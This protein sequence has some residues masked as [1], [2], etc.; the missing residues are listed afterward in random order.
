MLRTN[1]IQK[2][3]DDNSYSNYL[4]IGLGLGKN[5]NDINI[6]NKVSVDPNTE[7]GAIHQMTSDEF[8][9]SNT[10]TYDIVLVDGL[11]HAD[12]VLKDIE[13]SLKIADVVVCHDM[14]PVKKEH[15]V[16]PFSGGHWNGDCWKALVQLRQ[17][18]SDIEVVT[19]NTDEG[20]SVITKTDNG[21]TLDNELELTWENFDRN[22]EQWLNLITPEQFLQ[23]DLKSL[24]KTYLQDPDSADAN[25]KL[26]LH[27]ENIGQ[28]ASA[29]SYYVRAAERYKDK[30]YQYECMMRS[31]MCFAKQGIR[32]FSVKGMLQHAVAVLPER[33]EAYYHLTKIL[34]NEHG[35]GSWFDS[36]TYSSL[37]LKFCE[38]IEQLPPLR[39]HIDYPGLYALEFEQAH[40]AWHC[41]LCEESRDL[42]R[43]LFKRSDIPQ[44]L[45]E[46]IK[47]NLV[48]MNAFH[49]E[50]I[51]PYRMMDHKDMRHKFVGLDSI[52]KNYSE[53]FQ[54]MF[55]LAMTDGKRDGTYVEIGAGQS[56]YGNNTALL[57][58]TF[59]W[60]G[61]SFDLNEDFVKQHNETRSHTCLRRD[62]TNVDYAK[63]LTA[64]DFPTDIDYLQID[65]DPPEVSFRVLM[66]IPFETHRF[67]VITFEHD[68]Y[69]DPDNSIRENS[70]KYLESY[71]YQLVVNNIAPDDFREYEDWWVHPD[72]VDP[73]IVKKMTLLNDQPKKAKKYML[74]EL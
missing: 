28:C 49:T 27:Y 37:A 25:W 56:H 4:E 9:A 42:H 21:K 38:P 73:A 54:D 32:K 14:N 7:Y 66:N 13:N 67:A 61:I 53:S 10:D 62:A 46:I 50:K 63:L 68:H 44:Q 17:T 72:L 36:Y 47:N 40:A 34:N 43:E 71:G 48:L 70:R 3:I 59:G 20:V 60:K 51:E 58:E 24:I 6:K 57:E 11:H 41:G 15:Q 29:I 52:K 8:F 65:C 55:V 39:T 22:R 33:P 5:F 35:D 19:V 69:A 16:I 23:Q 1:I 26:G 64:L 31:A 45:K 30:L 18:R 74:R 2:L 12:Q